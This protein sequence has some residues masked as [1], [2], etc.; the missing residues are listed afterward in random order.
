M[1]SLYTFDKEKSKIQVKKKNEKTLTTKKKVENSRSQLELRKK[2]S[3]KICNS[4]ETPWINVLVIKLSRKLF[5]VDTGATVSVFP[6]PVPLQRVLHPQGVLPG[7]DVSGQHPQDRHHHA[8]QPLRVCLHACWFAQRRF[9]VPAHDGPHLGWFAFHF[10]YL[11]DVLVVSPDH[12]SHR[13]HLCEVRRHLHKNGLTTNQQKSVLVR[14]RSSFGLWNLATPWPHAGCHPV[15]TPVDTRTSAFPRARQLL[16]TF[17]QG[18]SRIFAP[19]HRRTSGTW[20]V[21]AVVSAYGP[22]F[23]HCKVSLGRQA[24]APSGGHPN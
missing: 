13:Q 24:Q 3:F 8:L 9:N 7:R 14:R 21:S 2:A 16:L 11:D 18:H 1:N 15:S 22:G 6:H 19:P 10:V 12:A 20:Q 4:S 5:L 23:Q 17:P